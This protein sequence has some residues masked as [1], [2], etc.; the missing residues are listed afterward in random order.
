MPWLAAF[1]L[2]YIILTHNVKTWFFKK[3]GVD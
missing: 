1:L 3:Y 2:A